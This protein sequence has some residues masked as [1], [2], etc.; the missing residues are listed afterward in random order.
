MA[1]LL[2]RGLDL[3]RGYSDPLMVLETQMLVQNV[4]IECFE[5]VV[6][7]EVLVRA[8]E[9]CGL[10]ES[11]RRCSAADARKLFSC[12]PALFSKFNTDFS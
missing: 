7:A 3:Y 8:I 10:P 6:D 4:R 12:V 9:T 1:S 11:K 5:S 2:E